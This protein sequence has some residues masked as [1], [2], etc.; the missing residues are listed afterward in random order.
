M[1]C[2]LK[3]YFKIIIPLGIV[4]ILLFS[5]IHIINIKLNA[6]ENAKGASNWTQ[7]TNSDFKDG[8]FDKSVCVGS[9]EFGELRLNFSYVN[10]WSKTNPIS[11]PSDREYHI[12]AS[13]YNTD[14]ILLFGGHWG[15][16]K[17]ETWIYDYSENNWINKNPQGLKPS[18]RAGHAMASI[19]G[20]DKV[21]LF[22]GYPGGSSYDD[23]TWVYD[24]SENKWTL[25]TPQNTP[26]ARTTH[27]M[28]SIYG[29]D[30]VLLFGGY[31]D[32]GTHDDTWIYDL[33]DDDWSE[34]KSL[35]IKPNGRE[36]HPLTSIYGTDKVLLFGGY[37]T[38]VGDLDDTWIFDY[39]DNTWVKKN[40]SNKPSNK[41]AHD[42][43]SISGTDKVILFGG[44]KD[45]NET[46]IYNLSN[47]S[48]TQIYPSNFPMA[49]KFHSMDCIYGTGTIVLFGGSD[50][51]DETWIYRSY[52][53]YSEGTFISSTKLVEKN[54]TYTNLS[55]DVYISKNTSIK[56][57]LRT[58][59][60]QLDLLNKNFVG[61]DGSTNM[62]YTNSLSDIWSGHKGE[63]W[64]QYKVFLKTL[65]TRESP[66][67]KNLTI[68]YN[69][70]PDTILI[71]PTNGSMISNNKP[72]FNWDFLDKDSNLQLAFQI[73]IDND[74]DFTSI[75]YDSGEQIST[76]QSWAFPTGTYYEKLIDGTWYWT[77]RTKDDD[78][79]WGYYSQKWELTIDSTAPHSAPIFPENN[80]FYNKLEKISGITSDGTISSGINKTEIAIKRLSN[81]YYWDGNKWNPLKAWLLTNGIS[82]WTYN[83]KDIIWDSNTQYNIQSRASDNASNIENPDSGNKFLI[84]KDSPSSFILNPINNTWV[85]NL[86]IISGSSIDYGGSELNEIKITIMRTTDNKYWS[87]KDWILNEQWL[88]VMELTE[89][90]YDSSLITWETGTQYIVRS[91]AIDKAGNSEISGLR[92]L[93]NYDNQKPDILSIE[94][95][96]NTN[97]TNSTSVILSLSAEDIGSGISGMS[98]S[99]DNET[100]SD[101]EPYNKTKTF[102]LPKGDGEKNIYFRIQDYAKNIDITRN[103]IILDTTPPY[104]LSIIINNG[105]LQTNSTQVILYLNAIDDLS[106]LN[107]MSFSL[108][109]KNWTNWEK[110]EEIKIFT[111]S[112]GDGEKTIYFKVKDFVENIAIPVF[113]TIILK[114][115]LFQ[116]SDGDNYPDDVDVFP[117]DPSQWKDTDGDNYGDNPNGTNPDYYP[118]DRS[119]W[120]KS[121]D[122]KDPENKND[123]DLN[124]IILSVIII[125]IAII[126]LILFLMMK[127]KKKEEI[128][129]KSNLE[130]NQAI[131]TQQ[132]I[133]QIS[134]IS[135]QPQPYQPSQQVQMMLKTPDLHIQ[136]PTQETQNED[137]YQ[138]YTQSS[139]IQ[140]QSQ[141]Q[142][143]QPSQPPQSTQTQNQIANKINTQDQNTY[144]FQKINQEQ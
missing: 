55:L 2:T 109:G 103:T 138:H 98:F 11:S 135:Q 45:G 50:G 58:S 8:I 41:R 136:K 38:G 137:L 130:S 16:Y 43:S 97:Y 112:S 64:I 22:G 66:I 134:H 78:G 28:A 123:N 122:I 10:E 39:S 33:S 69:I 54:I 85:N 144:S 52:S 18:G 94:I 1:P 31:S 115:T 59:Q 121:D 90:F 71:S 32:L 89:W 140:Y 79:D 26:S 56:I 6:F 75:E 128:K 44:T 114:T 15:T 84:D 9:N 36:N 95:N 7:T 80:G 132:Q 126:L 113:N 27:A 87:E 17:D 12:M 37:T 40:P 46:W 92:T 34:K 14:K 120:K 107:S 76:N 142:I 96:N 29:T 86:D 108:N 70:W 129:Q 143:Q 141:Q 106:G 102:N 65:S 100:W 35:I 47:N 101:W 62:Y 73:L 116:D 57:L 125:T 42:I 48:W 49:R 74:N 53:Y 21:L 25:K 82:M 68:G 20:T 124:W 4:I 51:S 13:I 88:D 81:N 133:P 77:V 67:L 99:T 24:L 72:I 61:P 19:H 127:R 63:E 118:N 23:K 5:S 111:L 105:S 60:N 3:N 91:K 119:R 110:Y 30:K 139:Q 93:F 83:S 131:E 104:L 117:K